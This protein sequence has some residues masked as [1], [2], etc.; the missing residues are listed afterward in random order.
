MQAG[1]NSLALLEEFQ[2]I[3]ETERLTLLETAE[4]LSLET[5]LSALSR[6]YL[7]RK[8]TYGSND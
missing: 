2:A 1:G 4:L 3:A 5:R 6:A 7:Q 8:L